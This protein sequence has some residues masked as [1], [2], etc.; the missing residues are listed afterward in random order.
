LVLENLE[1]T[2]GRISLWVEANRNAIEV[3]SP[4]EDALPDGQDPIQGMVTGTLANM[5]LAEKALKAS[6]WAAD[7]EC[8]CT[9][10][11]AR[12]LS[13]LDLLPP[14]VSKGW[15]LARLAGRLGIDRK[16][17]M[18]IGDNWNDMTCWSGPDRA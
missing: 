15:A 18:A 3:V 13:I 16:E 12:D 6:E 7:C 17:T 1:M 2:H 4:L 5:R 14:G 8:V 10:Y 11:P 9:E